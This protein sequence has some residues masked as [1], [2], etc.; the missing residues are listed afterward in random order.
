MWLIHRPRQLRE[1]LTSQQCP[2]EPR[3]QLD[4][5]IPEWDPTLPPTK[6]RTLPPTTSHARLPQQTLECLCLRSK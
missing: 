5:T 6:I 4:E 3:P 2:Q 1:L